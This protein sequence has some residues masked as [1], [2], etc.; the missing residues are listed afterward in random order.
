MQTFEQ[1]EPRDTIQNQRHETSRAPGM[2]HLATVFDAARRDVRIAVSLT[3]PRF[4]DISVSIS[5]LNEYVQ[6]YDIHLLDKAEL[7]P[8]MLSDFDGTLT[9]GKSGSKIFEY[10]AEVG[11]FLPAVR[12]KLDQMLEY[13]A[14]P[15]IPESGEGQDF[16]RVLR[17]FREWSSNND[18]SAKAKEEG[19]QR[20]YEMLS[21]IYAGHTKDEVKQFAHR[22]FE[23]IGYEGLY[24]DGSKKLVDTLRDKGIETLVI[25]VKFQ[26]ILEAAVEYFGIS[27]NMVAGMNLESDAAGR[28]TTTIKP[29]V[30]FRQGKIAA[31]ENLL[32]QFR[33]GR[34]VGARALFAMGDSPSKSDQQLLEMAH[35]ALATEPQTPK[36][37]EYMREIIQG[38]RRALI[39]DYEHTNNGEAVG[40]FDRTK[41][42]QE[43]PK[44]K[45]L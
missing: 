15:S 34:S 21:W 35:V 44:E 28:Y 23:A 18:L 2:S 17:A 5:E 39:V 7:L 22:A 16:L 43:P 25:S 11:F 27:P 1:K 13:F 8:V 9:S 36:D 10:G 42:T 24:F 20:V 41:E 6:Q 3:T 14:L 30:T 40:S 32:A 33:N 26:P 31:A 37:A 19:T 29:P 38:G 45:F 12:S 4:S